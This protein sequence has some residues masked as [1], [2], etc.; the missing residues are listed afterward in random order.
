VCAS[1]RSLSK[2]AYTKKQGEGSKN[3]ILKTPEPS[4]A[5]GFCFGCKKYIKTSALAVVCEKR[6]LH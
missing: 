6:V 4:K 2:G 3:G 1:S 5:P